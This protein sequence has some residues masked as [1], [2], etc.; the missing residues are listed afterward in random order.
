MHNSHILT[1]DS[2]L[3]I[4]NHIIFVSPLLAKTQ[5][6]YKS[7]MAQA[8]AR[9]RR[10]GQK[11]RVHIYHVIAQRTIDV[12]ILEHRYRRSDA[13]TTLTS[14]T[15][16]PE[17]S[18][19]KKEK[20]KLVRNNKGEMMLVP[21]SWLADESKREIMGI[22]DSTEKFTSLINFSE[23]FEQEDDEP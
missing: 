18:S 16:L 22:E 20:T 6:E 17:P 12:D 4:A 1:T 9:S 10:Y 14:T 8:I 15:E 5:Y 7:A 13:I 23:T 3:T 21:L 19:N 11:K 2:N